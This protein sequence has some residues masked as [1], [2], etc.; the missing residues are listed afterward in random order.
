MMDQRDELFEEVYQRYRSEVWALVYAYCMNSETAL[1]I[2]QEAFLRLW[3]QGE[4]GQ[5]IEQ[6]R[7]WLR[8]VAR[9]LAKDHN[10]CAFRPSSGNTAS[11]SGTCAAGTQ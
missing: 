1:E 3:E 6:P 5:H 4:R 9:N 11:P 10:R 7:A 8:R 2:T